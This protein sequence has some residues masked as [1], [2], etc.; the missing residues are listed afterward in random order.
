V[1]AQRC[2]SAEIAAASPLGN[3]RCFA[4]T[5]VFV[6]LFKGGNVK[7]C[8]GGLLAKKL[9]KTSRARCVPPTGWQCFPDSAAVLANLDRQAAGGNQ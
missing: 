2:S 3:N 6:K 9:D 8:R 5:E 1:V 7:L 4:S